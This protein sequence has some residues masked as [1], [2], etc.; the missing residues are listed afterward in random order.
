MQEMHSFVIT[1][2]NGK[3]QFF[4]ESSLHNH[5]FEQRFMEINRV[6]TSLS[7][8]CTA[9]SKRR[10]IFFQFFFSNH[11]LEHK[12][13][14]INLSEACKTDSKLRTRWLITCIGVKAVISDRL[15]DIYGLSTEYR[16]L[17][18]RRN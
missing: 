4:T 14:R 3:E 8:T 18:D 5:C 6:E 17:Y 16:G 10:T 13:M 15:T 11:C 1:N 2:I 12:F 7:Q 9:V